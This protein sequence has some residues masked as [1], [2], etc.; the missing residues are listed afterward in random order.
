[1]RITFSSPMRVEASRVGERDVPAVAVSPTV[2]S[3]TMPDDLGDGLL[4]VFGRWDDGQ[5]RGDQMY[6]FAIGAA[7]VLVHA[8][9]GSA[10]IEAR[11]TGT[12]RLSLI[13]RGRVIRS[14][15]AAVA[16]PGR[17]TFRVRSARRARLRV[18]F[19]PPTGPPIALR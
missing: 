4:A 8:R 16:A 12:V 7:A 3:V 19:T 11:T 6:A 9:S 17:H 15:R 13:R 18:T 5:S 10:T 14:R 2:W 1:V